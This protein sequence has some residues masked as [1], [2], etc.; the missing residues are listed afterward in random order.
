MLICSQFWKPF[1]GRGRNCFYCH[2]LN[3][4]DQG[5]ATCPS[6]A[7]THK[8]ARG[9]SSALDPPGGNTYCRIDKRSRQNANLIDNGRKDLTDFARIW[10]VAQHPFPKSVH[11]EGNLGYHT[12]TSG[13]YIFYHSFFYLFTITKPKQ[14]FFSEHQVGFER[15]TI[16]AHSDIDSPAEK[17]KCLTSDK[18]EIR[19]YMYFFCARIFRRFPSF[20]IILTATTIICCHF[21]SF[22]A[23]IAA[24]F[25]PFL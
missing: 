25:C 14:L 23:E 1:T 6:D 12:D 3:R 21:P 7:P 20:S 24:I 5:K 9:S 13:I 15:E 10:L 17:F 2:I 8:S 4:Q 11:Y 22:L 18:G 19:K 16:D